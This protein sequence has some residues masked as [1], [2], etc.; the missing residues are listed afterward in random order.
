MARRVRPWEPGNFAL[1][2][3]SRS[4]HWR[5]RP[6]RRGGMRRRDFLATA[7]ATL[8]APHI[9]RAEAARPL[10]FIPQADLATLDPHWTTAYVTRNHG[11]LVFDTLYGSDG[12]FSPS[13]QMLAGHVI[14]DD[15][16]RWTL[17]LRENLWWHDG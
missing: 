10:R 13:A 5:R 12:S 15:G 6:E 3:G 14:E 4:A 16:R 7:A 1:R 11:Y 8:A 17:T 9:A 2:A